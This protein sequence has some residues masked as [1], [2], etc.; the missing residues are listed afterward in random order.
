MWFI[1]NTTMIEKCEAKMSQILEKLR[2]P[3]EQSDKEALE[4]LK[5]LVDGVI[6]YYSGIIEKLQNHKTFG[7]D[8]C[9][10]DDLFSNPNAKIIIFTCEERAVYKGN[11]AI[12]FGKTKINGQPFKKQV[13]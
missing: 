2:Q 8:Y 11:N 1:R 10:D 5:Q 13:F 4:R 9:L 7:T 6:L 12:K 3:G